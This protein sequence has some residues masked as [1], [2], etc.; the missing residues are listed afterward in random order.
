M[1]IAKSQKKGFSLLEVIMSVFVITLVLVSAMSLAGR[2]TILARQTSLSYEA[3][4]LAEDSFAMIQSHIYDRSFFTT[5]IFGELVSNC[6][7]ADG[8]VF[9]LFDSLETQIV[10]CNGEC[11]QMVLVND[12]GVIRQTYSP[13][14]GEVLPYRRQINVTD[15][16][17]EEITVTVTIYWTNRNRDFSRTYTRNYVDWHNMV[18]Y[19]DY[20]RVITSVIECPDEADLPNWGAGGPSLSPYLQAIPATSSLAIGP[21][22]ATDWLLDN[23]Q[24]FASPD[25]YLQWGYM[26]WDPDSY[27]IGP[28]GVHHLTGDFVGEA[29][30]SQRPFDQTDTYNTALVRDPLIT[31]WRTIYPTDEDGRTAVFIPDILSD[32]FALRLVLKP[33]YVPFSFYFDPQLSSW[34]RPRDQDNVSSEFYCHTD[35]LN[36]DNFDLVEI[37]PGGNVYYC[38][39]FVA[40]S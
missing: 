6:S 39:A 4:M 24:C 9:D 20:G 21:D 31:E 8:C 38:I 30:G 34:T 28:N 11:P 3:A 35:V 19:Y 10:Q 13:V 32:Y 1:I 36:Y 29:D 40:P 23:P 26:E 16:P 25:W 12:M 7:S 37:V 17:G 33:N 5:D 15:N 27:A 22:T 2:A 18:D 14:E